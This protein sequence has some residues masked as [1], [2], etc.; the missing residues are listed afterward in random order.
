MYFKLQIL[1]KM[2]S[3]DVFKV[4]L[5]YSLSTSALLENPTLCLQYP[6]VYTFINTK[7]SYECS[8]PT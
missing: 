7:Y 2:L 6:E 1:S 5:V 4:M 8:R 3:V